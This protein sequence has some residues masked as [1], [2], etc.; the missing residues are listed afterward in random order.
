[1]IIPYHQYT[2]AELHPGRVTA[3]LFA[4][5]QTQ[6]GPADGTR[7]FYKS[8]RLYFANSKDHMMFLLKWS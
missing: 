1:M 8:P 5:L 7:W 6:F 4:W 2:V 3:E